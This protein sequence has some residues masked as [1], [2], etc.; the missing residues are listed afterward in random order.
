MPFTVSKEFS[1]TDYGDGYEEMDAHHFA[2]VI[3]TFEPARAY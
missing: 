2:G 3:V 1:V